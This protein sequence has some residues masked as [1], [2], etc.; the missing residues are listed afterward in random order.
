MFNS[1]FTKMELQKIP[2]IFETVQAQISN[3]KFR[4]QEN[5]G[6]SEHVDWT[7][8][9]WTKYSLLENRIAN[10]FSSKVNVSSDS[11]LCLG[12]K[13]PDHLDAARIAEK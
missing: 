1:L 3:R 8:G 4:D 7:D 13:C 12:R 9:R 10:Q 2:M 6:L 5:C 11:V